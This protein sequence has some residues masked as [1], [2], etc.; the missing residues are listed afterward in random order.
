[1]LAAFTRYGCSAIRIAAIDGRDEA[2]TEK[3]I[4]TSGVS[5]LEAATL[6]SHLLA[7]VAAYESG[8][9]EVLVM[10][11]DVSFELIAKWPEA[12]TRMREALPHGYGALQLCVGQEPGRL[13]QL[14]LSAG[15]MVRYAAPAFWST[16]AYLIDR[17]GM[18]AVL[19]AFGARPPFNARSFSLSHV[20]D[21]L[22][23]AS[24]AREPSINGPWVARLPTFFSDVSDS[25]IHPNHAKHQ[26]RAASYI[27][28]AHQELQRN[29]YGPG[30]LLRYRCQRW[31]QLV[32]ERLGLHKRAE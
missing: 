31:Q 13:H 24:I 26:Q 1:M 14:Y 25:L 32:C 23:L 2:T 7:I 9:A 5:P 30:S 16:G 12:W 21:E 19:A 29:R 15:D 20:A 6:A 22:L 4:T 27:R 10:E 17:R 28:F 3:N 11:D 8:A 18:Q